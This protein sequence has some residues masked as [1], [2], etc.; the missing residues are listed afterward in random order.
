MST[1]RLTQA[2]CWFSAVARLTAS[3]IE[4]R[5]TI[6]VDAVVGFPQTVPNSNIGSLY[7]RYKPDL[8]IANGCVPFPAVDAEG[9]VSGGLNPTGATNGGCSSSTGMFHFPCWLGH[10][11]GLPD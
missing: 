9:N 11:Y 10:E 6:A 3:P 1:T 2:L 5:A 7:L 4:K 8:Y